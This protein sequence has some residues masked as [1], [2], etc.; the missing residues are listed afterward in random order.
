NR[1]VAVG[2]SVAF[3]GAGSSDPD[4]TIATYAWVFGDLGSASGV[5]VSHAYTAA[6]T[7][8]VTL[9]VTDNLG[10][11]GTGS[12]T[13][14]VTNSVAPLTV[15]LTSPSAGAVVSNTI[16]LMASASA[17]AARVEFYCD[18]QTVPL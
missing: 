5:S 6:G 14:T 2:T 13:V 1:T 17:S 10:A 3:S 15:T 11:T 12:A 4:G 9:T 8:I 7:F 18:S 16:P